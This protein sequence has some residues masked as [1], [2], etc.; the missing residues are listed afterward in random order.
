MDNAIKQKRTLGRLRKQEALLRTDIARLEKELGLETSNKRRKPTTVAFDSGHIDK[1]RH[2]LTT[3]SDEELY[4]I[5]HAVF[6]VL[7]ERLE[8]VELPVGN[9]VCAK[10]AHTEKPVGP[11][12]PPPRETE[13]YRFHVPTD[14]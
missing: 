9:S 13:P 11:F 10:N 1:V 3:A 7:R 14:I 2:L 5:F 12:R 6:P 4:E 8:K